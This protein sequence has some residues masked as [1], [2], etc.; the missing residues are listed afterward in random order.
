MYKP[1]IGEIFHVHTWRCKHAGGEKEDAYIYRALELGAKRI[2]FTDHAPFPG[3]PFRSRMDYEQLSEYLGTLAE[4]KKR[5]SGKIEILSGLEV[6]YLPGF[7]SYIDELRHM[8]GMDVMLL[9]QHMYETAPAQYSFSYAD[10]SEEFYGLFEAMMRGIETGCF[11]VVAHP[12]R[13]FRRRKQFGEAERNVAEAFIEAISERKN[14]ILLE[15]NLSSMRH[16][17]QYWMEFWD[18]IPPDICTVYGYD[19]H[20]VK[21]IERGWNRLSELRNLDV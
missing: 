14:M 6:E 9:G 3:N 10:Q 5:F 15:K 12:D 2:V 20:S 11:D 19:A 4:L 13:A 16:K 8:K 7:A 21:E 1:I 17:C 18:L